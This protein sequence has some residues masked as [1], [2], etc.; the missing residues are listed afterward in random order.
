MGDPVGVDVGIVEFGC[1]A[2]VAV[3]VGVGVDPV[4]ELF[5]DQCVVVVCVDTH[6]DRCWVVVECCELFCVVEHCFDWCA[7]L[8]RECGDDCLQ[9]DERFGSEGVV[10]WWRDDPD[11]LL[12]DVECVGEVGAHVERRLCVGLQC[13]L[14]IVLFC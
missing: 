7:G 6:V 9:L 14:V 4:V 3:G 1:D 11:P 10:Y 2:W 13:Q 8:A 5:G 12:W